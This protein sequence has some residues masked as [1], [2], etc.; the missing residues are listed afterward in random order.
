MSSENP[1]ADSPSFGRLQISSNAE[2]Y[3][4][5]K[6]GDSGDPWGTL[7]SIENVGVSWPWITKE[8]LLSFIKA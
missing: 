7:A 3:R 4:R 1:I 6:I 2:L 5:N 8:V